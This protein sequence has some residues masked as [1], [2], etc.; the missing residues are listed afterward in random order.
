M[1]LQRVRQLVVLPEEGLADLWDPLVGVL[2]EVAVHGF[3]RPERDVVQIDDVVVGA[4]VDERAELAVADG[5]RLLEVVRLSV[6]VQRHRRLLCPSLARCQTH[7]DDHC[8]HQIFL[9]IFSVLAI[10]A[11]KDIKIFVYLQ[12]KTK[13]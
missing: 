12:H 1:Q 9:H 10:F 11:C 3:P 13:N 8:L 7:R 5:Q 4:A 2:V 6:V